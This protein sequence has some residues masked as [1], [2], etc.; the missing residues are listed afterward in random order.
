MPVGLLE[1]AVLVAAGAGALYLANRESSTFQEAA[2]AEILNKSL[3]KFIVG[4]KADSLS[5]NLISGEVK[6]QDVQLKTSAFD[7]VGCASCPLCLLPPLA[8]SSILSCHSAPSTAERA[9]LRLLQST[10]SARRWLHRPDYH[11]FGLGE[12]SERTYQDI[13]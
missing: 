12:S 4:L 8:R 5:S 11:P 7:D 2:L 13:D 9:V 10:C 1:G 3:G 6:L